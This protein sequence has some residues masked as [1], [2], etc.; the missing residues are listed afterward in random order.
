M[1]T[2]DYI[3]IVISS[4]ALILSLISLIVTLVQKNRETKRTIKKTLADAL[5]SITKI[6]I[7]NAKLKGADDYT[8]DVKI[9]LRR[10]YNFQRRVQIAHADF[11]VQK[12][13]SI[14]TDIDC[15]VLAVGYSIIGEQDIAELYWNKAIAKSKSS[16]IKFIN[17][18]GYGS[19][20]FAI[21]K[22]NIGRQ[23][24]Y[25][26]INLISG[27]NDEDRYQLVDTYLMLADLELVHGTIE[28][29]DFCITKAMEANHSIM[30][31]QKKNELH[32]RIRLLLDKRK[33]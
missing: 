16:Y 4:C 25:E 28:D 7:E 29:I 31:P 13:D 5:E 14:A 12:Y 9:Q 19:Y 32:S 6:G 21:G 8:S 10:S 3:L 17:Y 24:F 18:R 20:L 15:A 26:A 33:D 11:L 1:V 2:K 22:E 30:N 27:K 23:M